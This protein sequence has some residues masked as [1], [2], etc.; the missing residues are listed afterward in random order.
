MEEM[1]ESIN[2]VLWGPFLI[3]LLIGVGVLYTVRLGFV[4][5][6]MAGHAFKQT[7]GG[8]FKKN[9]NDDG[10]S[11]FQALATAIAAQVGTGNLA[12][13]ATAITLGGPGAIFWMWASSLFGMA[14]I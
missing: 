5:F 4:Q 8:I 2:D 14:T 7:F 1:L 11:S 10:I 3:I 13:V 9:E 12:G 6:R